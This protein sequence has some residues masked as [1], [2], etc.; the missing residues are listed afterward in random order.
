MS[1]LDAFDSNSP[2][3]I[4]PAHVTQPV[5]N[6]PEIFI[7]TFKEQVLDLICEKYQAEEIS[8]MQAGGIRVPVYGFRY[9]GKWLGCYHT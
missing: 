6:C 9:A 5:K 8:S 1:I 2:E 4:T 3:I 7:A